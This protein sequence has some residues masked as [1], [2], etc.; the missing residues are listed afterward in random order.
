MA[1]QD[2]CC[3]LLQHVLNSFLGSLN[4]SIVGDIHILIKWNII[5]HA[6]KYFLTLKIYIF[7]G[8]L[9]HTHV[10]TKPPL[11]KIG[12]AQTKAGPQ[13]IFFCYCVLM[14]II[15]LTQQST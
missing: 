3:A 6:A 11:N 9:I 2:N 7:N 15:S 12:P 13:W 1:S 5:I 4:T 14:T 8:F 10:N